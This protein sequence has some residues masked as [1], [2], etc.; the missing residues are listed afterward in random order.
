MKRASVLALAMATL[1]ANLVCL[2]D[3]SGQEKA[4]GPILVFAAASTTSAVDEIRKEFTGQ[5]GVEVQVSY[6]S[7]ATLAQQIA[8]GAEAEVFLSADPQWADYLAKKGLVAQRRN[9]L[10][11][12]LVV[13]VPTDSP[14]KLTKLEDLATAGIEHLALGDP[15]GVPVGKYAK[16]A[17]AKLG[18]WES[19]RPKVVSAE[20]ARHALTYVET[21]AAEAGMVYATD[22]AISKKVKVAVAVPTELTEPIRYPVVLLKQGANHEAAK[23][24]FGRLQSPAA[25]N[26][27]KKYGFTLPALPDK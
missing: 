23:Q 9:L 19:L 18:L 15:Q 14:L 22:A 11:N 6:A 3:A 27:F 24:F 17:L 8:L 2:R 10:G 13:V 16:Q 25:A 26:V 1:A 21:G 20:D 12:R 4:K 5:T 7:S